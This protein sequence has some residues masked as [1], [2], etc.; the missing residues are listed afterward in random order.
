MR[1]TRS[2]TASASTP[3]ARTRRRHTAA[4]AN[5]PDGAFVL[6]DDAP[7]LVLGTNLLRWTPAGYEERAARPTRGRGALVTPPSLVHVLHTGWQ[8]LVPF[9]HPS[10][11]RPA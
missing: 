9:L 1:S 2:S 8:P 6:E 10:A 4:F 5:L 3:D 11:L 7:W